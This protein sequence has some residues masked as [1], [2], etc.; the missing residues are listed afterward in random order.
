MFEEITHIYR[1]HYGDIPGELVGLGDGWHVTHY[2]HH[3]NQFSI[4]ETREF[5]DEVSAQRYADK[6]NAEW[7]VTEQ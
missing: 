6:R 5:N 2:A 1:V 4:H 7:T 3:G